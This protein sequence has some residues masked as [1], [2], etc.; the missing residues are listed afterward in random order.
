MAK[1]KQ[2][3]DNHGSQVSEYVHFLQ[4]QR[5]DGDHRGIGREVSEFAS[6]GKAGGHGG[7]H[8]DGDG[9]GETDNGLPD[10][11]AGQILLV[12][13]GEVVKSDFTTIQSAIDYSA[14][15][16]VEGG[17]IVI[18]EGVY[19]ETLTVDYAVNIVGEDGAVIDGSGFES[20]AGLQSTVLLG[21]GFSGSSISNV[22]VIAIQ[23]GNALLTAIGDEVSNVTL[24]DNT[25]DGG[26]NTSGSVVYLNPDASNFTFEGNTFLGADLQV[27]PLLGVE[28]DNVQITG[29]AFGDTAGTYAEVEIFAAADGVTSDVVLLGNTGLPTSE[30]HYG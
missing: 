11:E 16:T 21:D 3:T 7:G 4:E 27:S 9:D 13:D 20:S 19:N 30:I 5:G 23:D 15:N 8:G 18:G 22:D 12:V 28:A 26:A 10:A 2:A 14:S 1:S 24:E 25:F 29:N 17:T 6:G